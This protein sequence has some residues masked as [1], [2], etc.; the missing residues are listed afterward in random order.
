MENIYS[1]NLFIE[2]LD[3]RNPCKDKIAIYKKFYLQKHKLLIILSNSNLVPKWVI[4]FWMRY[5]SKYFPVLS[6][7]N[8]KN[9]T[10]G[11]KT[12]VILIKNFF[13]K[14]DKNM[15]KKIYISGCEKSIAL[16][17]INNL[18]IKKKKTVQGNLQKN[19][20]SFTKHIYIIDISSKNYKCD[21]QLSIVSLLKNTNK[22]STFINN[23]I[24]NYCFIKHNFLDIRLKYKFLINNN[25][26]YILRRYLNNLVLKNRIPYY[27]LPFRY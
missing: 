21:N 13:A 10:Y 5:F 15:I 14:S 19:L 3:A 8:I 17:F 16:S 25:K 22:H 24:S 4:K 7:S 2:I 9:Q 6:I 23:L 26:N 20:Y 11:I 27:T 1:N 12:V 18:K